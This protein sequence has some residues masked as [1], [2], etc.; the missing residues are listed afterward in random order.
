LPG[1]SIADRPRRIGWNIDDCIEFS[2][3]VLLALVLA[4]LV[5]AV[6]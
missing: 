1:S 5:L 3:A 2:G 4:A 6:V